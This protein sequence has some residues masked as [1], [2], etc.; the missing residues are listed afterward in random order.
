MGEEVK[1]DEIKGNESA[2]K[3]V[4]FEQPIAPY[5]DENLQFDDYLKLLVS[6]DTRTAKS[7]GEPASKPEA[8]T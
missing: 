8:T 7:E 1:M 6:E 3:Q 4:M 5:I 2:P